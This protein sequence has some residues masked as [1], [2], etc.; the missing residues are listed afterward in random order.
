[1]WRGSRARGRPGR[2]SR[3]DDRAAAAPAGCAAAAARRASR[4]SSYCR[5]AAR[6]TR[7]RRARSRGCIR[8]RRAAARG[9]HRDRC[10][11]GSPAEPAPHVAEVARLAAVD[12][13][14]DAAGEHHAVDASQAC[15]RIGE[16]EMRDVVRQRARRQ[17]RDQR[18]GHR[19]RD[20]VHLG[21]GGA[22]AALPV[23]AGAP[24]VMAPGRI[25]PDD[26]AV[27]IDDLQPAADMHGRRRDHLAVL[28]DA[29][30]WWYRRRC[31]C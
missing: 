20:L 11:R 30:A 18:V 15:D 29:R 31:R 2:S 16:I 14:A 3:A 28:D 10:G 23:E 12:V 4:C 25:E 27:R 5:R 7:R 6:C 17:R 21:A 13:F 22:A 19:A 1:M 8:R 9:E 26:G 24:G